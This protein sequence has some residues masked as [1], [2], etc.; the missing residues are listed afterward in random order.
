MAT[1]KFENG[2]T[3]N[4]NGNPT[5]A[6][7]EEV[8]KSLNTGKT[9][10]TPSAFTPPAP[11]ISKERQ[12]DVATAQKYG[13][14]ATPNTENPSLLSEITKPIA[15]IPTSAW[16]FAKGIVDV[17]NPISTFGKVKQAVNEF[18]GLTEDAGGI[19]KATGLLAGELPKAT[20]ET[21]VPEA[22]RGVIQAGAGLVT[23]NK[24]DIGKGLQ[25]AQRAIVSDPVGQIAP[26]L[27]AGR[28]AA[29]AADSAL[30]KVA[31]KDYVGNMGGG[32]KGVMTGE[33]PTP[34]TKFGTAFDTAVSKVAEPIVRAGGAVKSGV[35]DLLSGGTKFGIGQATGLSP[36]TIETITEQ[37]SKFA[38]SERAGIDRISVGQDIQSSLA[39]RASNLEDTGAAYGPIREGN[40]SVKV[41]KN[42]LD[43]SIKT[44]TG[45]DIKGGRITASGESML[46][47]SG[48]VRAIQHL[49]DL[50][51]PVFKRGNMT[52]NEFLNFRS[53]LAKLSKFE[54][55]I[56]KSQPIESATKIMRG[57]FNEAFRPQL[58][59]L[60][61][62]DTE[63]SKQSSELREL[64]KGLVDR[65][66]NLT[67]AGLSKIANLSKIKPNLAAQLEQISPGITKKVQV[68]QA[69]EDIQHASGIK[70]GTYGRAA[71]AGS[72]L[73]LGGPLQA[74][75]TAIM[76][77]PEFAV[78]IIRRYG[79]IKNSSAIKSIV[80]ALKSAG[81]Q[82]NNLPNQ[83]PTALNKP[84]DEIKVPAGLSIEDVSKSKPSAFSPKVDGEAVTPKTALDK[85]G[86]PTKELPN[87]G[88]TLAKPE[89]NIKGVWYHG[90][91]IDNKASI[92]KNGINSALNKKGFAEQ[93]EAFYMADK[94]EAGM[95][96]A[97]KNA[98]GIR[99]KP[100]AKVKTIGADEF[101]AEQNSQ[102]KRGIDQINWARKNGYDAI[103][104]GDEIAVLNP[105]KFEVF[106]P[107]NTLGTEKFSLPENPAQ[108]A[109]F[110]RAAKWIT[111]WVSGKRAKAPDAEVQAWLNQFN[112]SK[113]VT[114]NRGGKSAEGKTLRSWSYNART[115]KEFGIE[116][117]NGGQSITQKVSPERIVADISNIAYNSDVFDA[118]LKTVK[119]KRLRSNIE[120]FMSGEGE[121][122]VKPVSN[123][124]KQ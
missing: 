34:T 37:P 101:T 69:V 21:F 71:L 103:N 56:G 94:G 67:D 5:P 79:L 63:F 45:N 124:G 38:K 39:K 20:Y 16:N 73:V 2:A 48:D 115:A 36:K 4:F 99:I 10:T 25:T 7:I 43:S 47:E 33:I 13:A 42:W 123:L 49:Y 113:P 22:G 85:N 8:S 119:D 6:D 97:D 105:S 12:A 83:L 111:E 28:A 122:V 54:R 102:F 88:T 109:V 27:L 31:M 17:F 30:S 11:T 77:S 66:G 44:I 18:K 82:V 14:I 108:Q 9:G 40:S 107:A 93:P 61:K 110:D 62:I 121:V 35:G 86:T 98:V 91:T 15:N 68:L 58:E 78:P 100:G 106:D 53:D 70:V 74:V 72:A 75:V 59:G 50:W 29:G 19:G 3:V 120:A 55:Q 32:G 23:G 60:D 104:H 51:K 114:L 24:E 76:T 80:Q 26:F 118:I 90:T 112:P 1:I 64:S 89:E 84:V 81:T 65:D 52:A 95:Y 92:L 117:D 46:R 87:G 116:N 96:G 41:G 57:Q